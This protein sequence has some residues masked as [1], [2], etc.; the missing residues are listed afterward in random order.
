MRKDARKPGT[1]SLDSVTGRRRE[2][3]EQEDGQSCY[4]LYTVV[5]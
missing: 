1:A 2:K 5:L 4:H 3:E